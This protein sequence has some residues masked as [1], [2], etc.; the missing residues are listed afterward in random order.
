MAPP[1]NP[2]GT[3]MATCQT[4]ESPYKIDSVQGATPEGTCAAYAAFTATWWGDP[5]PVFPYSLSGMTCTVDQ[6]QFGQSAVADVV[7]V[8]DAPDPVTPGTTVECGAAC[9]IAVQLTPAEPDPEH[10]ADIGT[11][12]A[13]FLGAAVLVYCM[14]QLLNLFRI[15]QHE[16]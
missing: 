5:K 4:W 6:S 15:N 11:L 10:I 8:C 7:H 1:V 12:F 13:L 9:S 2:L 3:H 16:D 14:R